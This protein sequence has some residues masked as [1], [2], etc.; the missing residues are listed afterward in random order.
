MS[1]LAPTPRPAGLDRARALAC[2]R[3]ERCGRPEC[4]PMAGRLCTL[5][6]AAARRRLS[7]A[8]RGGTA[9]AHPAAGMPR[10]ALSLLRR[11]TVLLRTQ[12]QLRH[13]GLRGR[14]AA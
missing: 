6:G 13:P 2:L 5:A 8:R 11:S 3:L 12:L 1:A 4:G 14:T 9:G 7:V 10:A